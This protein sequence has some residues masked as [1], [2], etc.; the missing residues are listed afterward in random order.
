MLN[1]NKNAIEFVNITKTF[2][3]IIANKDVNIKIKT[4]EIHALIGENGA[5][6]STLMSVLFGIYQ[7]NGGHILING[8]RVDV[9][10]YSLRA[11]D[12]ITVR[13]RFSDAPIL[14]TI[15]DRQKM[16]PKWHHLLL[17]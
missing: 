2:G 10:S 5:G 3:K 16:V 11:G 6:K 13:D 12:I 4:G 17:L 14:S 8:K 7:P 9:P 15:S 1:K